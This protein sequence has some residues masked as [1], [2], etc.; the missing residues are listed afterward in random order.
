M[1]EKKTTLPSLRNHDW[2]ILKSETK[3]INTLLTHISTYNILQLN[4][5]IYAKLVCDK[6]N[7]PRKNINRNSKHGWE[8]RLE[9]RIRNLLQ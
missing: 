8:I 5:L 3:K 1:S 7:V 2:K 4:E 6:I 9:I